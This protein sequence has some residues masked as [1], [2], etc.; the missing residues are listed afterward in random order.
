MAG[1]GAG[2]IA[3]RFQNINFVLALKSLSGSL[4]PL[5]ILGEREILTPL[6]P[7]GPALNIMFYLI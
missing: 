3:Q 5:N 7:L 6:F 1:G 4:G 2:Q